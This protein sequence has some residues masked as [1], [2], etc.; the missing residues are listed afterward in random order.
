MDSTVV[1]AAGPAFAGRVAALDRMV[2][3]EALKPRQ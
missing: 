1:V 2:N 3:H